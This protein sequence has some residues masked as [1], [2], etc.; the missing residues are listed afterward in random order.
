MIENLKFTQIGDYL[1][2]ETIE[3]IAELLH[4]YQDLFPMTFSKMKRIIG[5]L[6]EMKMPLKPGA[7]PM[8][9][10]TYRLNLKYKEKMKVEIDRM[11]DARIIEPIEEYEWISTMVV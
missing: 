4:E 2:D 10:R 11:L 5:D 9:Q 3:K 1:S 6:G 8:Q 7:K